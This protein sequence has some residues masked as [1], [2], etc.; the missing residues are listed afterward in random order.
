MEKSFGTFLREQ[1]LKAGYSLRAF[2]AK[3]E[4]K[5]SNLSF[6]ESGKANPPRSS[7]TLFRI[8]T[9]LGLKKGSRE[10]A[11]L[12]DLSTEETRIPADIAADKNIR[13]YLPIMLRTIAEA[14]LTKKQLEKLIDKIKATEES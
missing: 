6:M 3:V 8:A 5:P 2:A 1:R 13:N 14:R 4:I 11:G 12:F 7:E 10:W 9:A